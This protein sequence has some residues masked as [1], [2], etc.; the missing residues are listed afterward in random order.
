MNEAETVLAAKLAE[1]EAR[2]REVWKGHEREAVIEIVRSADEAA[3]AVRFLSPTGTD[4]RNYETIL[5]GV[6][7]ALATFLPALKGSGAGLPFRPSTPQVASWI[8]GMLLE[9]GKLAELQRIAAFER[10]G[11][12]KSERLDART[13]GIKFQATVAEA[14]DRDASRWL[15]AETMRRVALLQGP[16][17]DLKRIHDLLDST[18]GVQDGWMIRYDGHEELL[19][20]YGQRAMTEVLACVE[21][22]ALPH[23]AEIGGRLFAE[24]NA[25]CVAALGK[26]FAHIAYATRLRHRNPQLSLRNLLTIPVLRKDAEEVWLETGDEPDRVAST[27]SHL[28]L[29]ADSIKPWRDHHEIP[30]PFYIDVGGPWMLL[31]VFGALL[32]PVCGLVRT[33]RLRHGREWDSVVGRRED[34]FRVH[35]RN[36]FPSPR[37]VV[38]QRGFVLRRADGSHLTDVDAAILDRQTGTLALLQ[39]KWPDIF[40]LSPRERESRRL[41]L[42]KANEWV[43][44]VHSWIGGRSAK[45]IGKALGNGLDASTGDPLLIV[46][47]RYNARF[48]L[49]TG[50]D[51]RA[52]WVSWPEVVRLRTE[53]DVDNPLETLAHRFC[54]GGALEPHTPAADVVC[55]LHELDVRLSIV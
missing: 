30:A 13:I 50:L 23:E 32:N 47:P 25:V 54:A 2:A 46:I 36:R 51:D 6:A 53:S 16:P 41:N 55:N 35:I 3:F 49:N 8:D 18:S 11:L 43:G 28:M 37:F 15:G 14:M 4:A 7:P 17:P 21:A 42:L 29:D 33:L 39:L 44:R 48:G 40:G 1:L 22:E 5:H 20:C 38:P 9:F 10:Y 27:I 24:W 52:A 31:P 45:E 12:C 26:V 34:Y 19:E